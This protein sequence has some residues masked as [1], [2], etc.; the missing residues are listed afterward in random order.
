MEVSWTICPGWPQT[1]ILPI[2]V[3]QVARI[4]GVSCWCLAPL[5][6][7]GGRGG[8]P[9]YRDY[10]SKCRMQKSP[11]YQ[12]YICDFSFTTAKAYAHTMGST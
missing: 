11:I 8:F 6:T 3:S 2:S 12:Y 10:P 9:A 4:T 5:S 1:L 7:F